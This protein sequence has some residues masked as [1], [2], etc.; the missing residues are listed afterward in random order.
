MT[1]INEFIMGHPQGGIGVFLRYAQLEVY[2]REGQIYAAMGHIGNL[3]Q[4]GWGNLPLVK[5]YYTGLIQEPFPEDYKGVEIPVEYM[6][7]D[8]LLQ[9]QLQ[10]LS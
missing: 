5:N 10:P 4:E 6:T 8:S 3:T 2:L 7:I 1:N 9:H